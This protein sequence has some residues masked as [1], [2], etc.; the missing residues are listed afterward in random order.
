ML[1]T[2]AHAQTPDTPG[3]EAPTQ[4]PEPIIDAEDAQA[5]ASEEEAEVEEVVVTGTS[6]RGVAPAGSPVLAIT[7]EQIQNNPATTATELLRQLPQV[8]N[9][10][11]SD[12]QFT[13]SNNA[14]AN[15]TG[16][17]GINLRGLGTEAT[18]T[19]VDSRRMPAAGTMAQYFDP[20]VIPT[21]AIGRIEVLADGGSAIYGSDAVGGVVNILLRRNFQGLELSAR[22]GFADG[23]DQTVLGGVFGHKWSGGGLMVAVEYNERSNLLASERDFYTDDLRPFG[24]TDQRSFNANPG[25]IQVGNTR[26]AIPAGQNGRALTPAQLI[27]GTANRRSAFFE[28][29]ALP[30]QERLTSAFTFDHDLTDRIS[31]SAQGIFAK[32]EFVR[33]QGNFTSNL[34]VPRSNPF[35][36]HPTNPA[37]PNVTVNYSFNEDFGRSE[38]VADSDFRFVTGNFDVELGADWSATA[39]AS[40]GEDTENSFASSVNTAALNRA[41]ADPNAATAFNPFGAGSNTPQA[42]LDLIEARFRIASEY[43]LEEFGVTANGPVFT[44]PGG[45][46]RAAIGLSR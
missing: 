15:V 32:R 44:L 14:N 42:T 3:A 46:V 16:G 17:S 38:R 4:T 13:A 21:M 35:F 25:N 34:T 2:G 7:P 8:F 24:G 36:V 1:T 37:A 40:H 23:L 43:T 31:F 11:A 27:P 10:G 20:S 45:E 22:Y 26:Y 28:A 19:L 39:Y 12:T 29:D 18:L 6:I 30:A 5:M 33:G 9:L 41:L